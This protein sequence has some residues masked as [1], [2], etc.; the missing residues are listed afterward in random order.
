MVQDKSDRSKLLLMCESF[1][2]GS[3]QLSL[4]EG[5]YITSTQALMPNS[6]DDDLIPL[7]AHTK[8]SWKLCQ[9]VSRKKPKA[10]QMHKYKCYREKICF[11]DI[12]LIVHSTT[13]FQAVNEIENEQ[14]LASLDRKSIRSQMIVIEHVSTRRRPLTSIKVAAFAML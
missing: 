9:T 6:I 7:Q 4:R 11:I 2:A 1:G 14:A 10:M 5:P 13:E 12:F 8:R 3:M